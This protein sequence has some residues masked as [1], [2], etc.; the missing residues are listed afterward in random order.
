MSKKIVRKCQ[1]EVLLQE[2]IHIDNGGTT[3]ELVVHETEKQGP[4][5][6]SLNISDGY[7]GY[8]DSMLS[9]FSIC[10]DPNNFR[11]LSEFFLKVAML[12]EEK[13]KSDKEKY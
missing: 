11:K 13:R 1:E 4:H 6:A 7:F 9:L 10:D 2:H 12:L 3:F 8:S 5:I